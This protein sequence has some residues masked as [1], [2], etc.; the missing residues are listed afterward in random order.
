MF[1]TGVRQ[2]RLA[3]S[4]VMGRPINT[5]NV[6][7]LIG[8]ALATLEAF[9]S[10]G[11]D[12]QEMLDGPFS[13]PQARRAFQEQALRRTA[14]RLAERSPH[15]R[16]LFGSIDLDV[17]GLTLED[18]AAIPA[19]A[20]ADLVA[21]PADFV[22]DGA[23]PHVTTRTTG[24]TGRPAEIWLSRYELELWP[25]LA[26][27]S[28][29]LRGE[30]APADCMQINISSRATAAMTQ[31]MA[32]CR[33][34]GARTRPLGLV[35]AAESLDSLLTGGDRA[36]TLLATYPSYLAQLVRLARRQ[37]LGP[38][39]FNLR[40]IDCGGEV[41]SPALARAAYDTLG[42]ALV[43]DSF[44]M[45]EVLPVSGRAC[46]QGHLH[47]DLNMGFVEV[48]DLDTGEPAAAG[49]LGTVVI[50]PY[51]PYRE[52]MPVFRYDTRDVVR[53]LADGDLGCSLSGTPA[54]SQILG[55]AGHLL[56]VGAGVVTPREIVEACEALPGEPWPARFRADFTAGELRLVLSQDTAG[57]LTCEQ[58]ARRIGLDERGLPVTCSVVA[59][60]APA[61]LRPLRADLAER[62]F[63]AERS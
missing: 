27:L 47:H 6:E 59:A 37:G 2:L 20:K 32:V 3:M 19:T 45:T 29:L 34:V 9:G 60:P 13:D 28:G 62:T 14:R 58:L 18:M 63:T 43:N 42:P 31:N 50:T 4:M 21:R 36:P 53:R 44:G 56:H 51:F 16:E 46:E 17:K 26:A 35:P 39:D 48:I 57:T 10:P 8:D 55:K 49:E 61:V 11:D 30:I 40:R 7:R 15:Y 22:V 24:T 5:R 41:L 1:E 38:E 54:T 23:S 33:L 12:L 52:C 25:A